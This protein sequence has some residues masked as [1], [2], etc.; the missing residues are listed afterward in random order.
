VDFWGDN[1]KPQTRNQ[2]GTGT[3]EDFDPQVHLTQSFTGVGFYFNPRVTR[4]QLEIWFILY[5]A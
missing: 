4:T 5:F 3:G 1:F 2:M